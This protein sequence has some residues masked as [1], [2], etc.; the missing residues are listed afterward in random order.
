M[1]VR[2]SRIADLPVNRVDEIV[3]GFRTGRYPRGD[4]P[5]IQGFV[6][7][8]AAVDREHGRVCAM[9]VWEDAVALRTS[10]K[11]AEATRDAVAAEPLIDEYEIAEWRVGRSEPG[12]SIRVSRFAGLVEKRARA[13]VE[14]FTDNIRGIEQLPGYQGYL[15]ASSIREGK[16]TSISQWASREHLEH[17]ERAAAAFRERQ[18]A[19]MKPYRRPIVDIYEIVTVQLAEDRLPMAA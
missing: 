8:A 17:S 19:D 18:L 5:S 13:I 6:G 10:R 15:L 2:L 4:L 3:E 1:H 9:S 12:S 7:Y 14:G 11:A 16:L